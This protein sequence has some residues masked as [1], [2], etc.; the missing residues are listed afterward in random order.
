MTNY[1]TAASQIK[2]GIDGVIVP[3]DELYT[4]KELVEFIRD[5]QKRR[6]IIGYLNHHD[7]GNES[8]AEKVYDLIED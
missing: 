8:E 4:A 1:P 2:D 3:M 6:E 5:R 7:Y